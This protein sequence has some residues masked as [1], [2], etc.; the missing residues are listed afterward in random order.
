MNGVLIYLNLKF[1]LPYLWVV[2]IKPS[3]KSKLNSRRDSKCASKL[4]QECCPK[5]LGIE[6]STMNEVKEETGDLS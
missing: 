4:M 5:H 6:A 3:E 2:I 1:K